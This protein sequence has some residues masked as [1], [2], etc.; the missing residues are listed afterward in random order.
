MFVCI[1]LHIN[2][3]Q[4]QSESLEEINMNI[5]ANMNVQLRACVSISMRIPNTTSREAGFI[6]VAQVVECC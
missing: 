3:M 6:G 5:I 1:N 4:E 2:I